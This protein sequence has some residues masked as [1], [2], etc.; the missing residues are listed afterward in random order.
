V[1][2]NGHADPSK[3]LLTHREAAKMLS[4]S[5]RTLWKLAQTGVIPAVRFPGNRAVRYSREALQERIAQLQA[6]ANSGG[7]PSKII[8]DEQNSI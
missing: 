6:P 1:N 7:N 2:N 8:P 4:L 5:E 3:L